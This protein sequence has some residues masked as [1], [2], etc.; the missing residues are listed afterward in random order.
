MTTK[1]APGP[2]TI[3][4][5][6]HGYGVRA[7]QWGYVAIH[8]TSPHAHWNEGQAANRALI[9]AAPELLEALAKI[10]D[11]AEQRAFEDWLASNCPSGCVEQVQD[12]WEQSSEFAD[13]CDD[14]EVE[15]AAIA[16]ARGEA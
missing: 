16:K 3:E 14:W 10:V 6:T 11:N 4:K 13:F 1:H 9:A 7:P 2:W 15:R 12:Q 5:T 8:D